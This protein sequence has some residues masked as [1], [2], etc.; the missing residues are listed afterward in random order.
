MH[1]KL[2]PEE[3]EAIRNFQASREDNGQ[4]VEI[5]KH[6]EHHTCNVTVIMTA[7]Q[8]IGVLGADH[9]YLQ[10]KNGKERADNLWLMAHNLAQHQGTA[11]HHG[12]KSHVRRVENEQDLL[13]DLPNYH[14]LAQLAERIW[15]ESQATKAKV[16]IALTG[17]FSEPG[18]E[19][20]VGSRLWAKIQ[21]VWGES[22]DFDR[23]TAAAK[24]R[25]LANR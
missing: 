10:G 7:G 1:R 5:F 15:K 6:L 2:S 19:P 23:I 24:E 21:S 25:I 4:A 9:P 20:L 17:M 12:P 13:D 8:I 14:P 18:E 16:C 22:P 11:R 3:V